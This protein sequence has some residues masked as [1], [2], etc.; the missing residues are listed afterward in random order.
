MTTN[1]MAQLGAT[2]LERGYPVLPIQP[3]SKKPG[4]YRMGSWCDYPKW[5]RHCT[6]ATTENEVD[7]W[8]DWPEA[9]IGIA[10]GQLVGVDI[11]VS[12][13][14]QTAL[15][16]EALAKRLLGD[17]PAVRIGKAPK[18]LLVY[19]AAQPFAGFKY[20]PIEILGQGQQFVA[21]GVHPITERPYEWPVST[22]A[23]I[24]ASDLPVITDAQAREFAQ[25]AYELIPPELRPRSLTLGKAALEASNEAL[26]NLAE[27][28][29][30]LE[31]VREAITFIANEDLDYDSWI[32]VG[33]AIKGAL[34]EVGQELFAQWSASSGKNDA[35]TTDKS[36]HSFKPQRIGAGTIYK[37]ALDNGWVPAPDLLLNGERVQG[38]AHPAH[39][40]IASLNAP[41][42]SDAR[43]Q[44]ERMPKPQMPSG[45][46][47]VGGV[48]AE[49]MDL[50]VSTAKRPQPVL[51]LGASLCALGALMGRKYRTETNMRSNLYVVGIAESG[52]GKNH[53]RVVINELFKQAGLRRYI[54][55][56]KIASGAGLLRALLRQP[57]ILFQIDE[58][59]MFLTAATDRKRSPRYLT[60]VVDLMT[61]LFTMSNSTYFGAEYGSLQNENAYKPI[62]QPCACV[63]GTTTPIHFWQALQAANVADGSLARFLVFVTDEDFPEDN[64]EFG[65]VEPSRRLIDKIKLIQRGGDRVKGNLA[66]VAGVE[67]V[68][69]RPRVVPMSP[70][71]KAVFRGLREDTRAQ[72]IQSRGK[73]VTSI[74]AR[75]EENTSKL[76][77]IRAVSRNPVDPIMD[78][79]DIEWG[80]LIAKH[81]AE[82]TIRE[83]NARVS[84][85]QTESNHKRALEILRGA[86][87]SGMGRADFTRR[88][89]FMD[90]RQREAVI[91]TLV[92]AQL[93]EVTH[94]ANKLG[95]PAQW[96]RGL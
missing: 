19:R 1:Y 28:R 87:A 32:R 53:S 55:G 94:V 51:A 79:G 27:Q 22:L 84:E 11:D 89:Q 20:P 71:A 46:D 58:F 15:R 4:M 56:N 6:R 78:G 13:D 82:L 41:I 35:A 91:E 62:E 59:G 8:G 37:L 12:G 9:G 30:T 50:M 73:G 72:L 49:M 80:A 92:D 23:D 96:F 16:I 83:V 52:S 77:L 69:V 57:S 60:E 61:E 3:R 86:G 39:E 63:Y 95:R 33:M 18:R 36:W 65:L 75:I 31:A 43:S 7:I 24:D 29:G 42:T 64:D 10:A 81:C 47:N 2:L 26:V 76:A 67:E 5:S 21:Y 88:T 85:N 48:L 90:K 93:V 45:W 44:H 17:T 66:E 34:G 68:D 25:S 70:Q 40:L 14:E 54:G 74:L 38:Q